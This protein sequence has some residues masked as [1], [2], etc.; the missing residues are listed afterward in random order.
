MDETR[1]T[2][3][4]KRT[5]FLTINKRNLLFQCNKSLP[6]LS[7]CNK[8]A[9]NWCKWHQLL[10]TKRSRNNKNKICV[11]SYIWNLVIWINF[12]T[13]VFFFLAIWFSWYCLG[14]F[15]IFFLLPLKWTSC[16]WFVSS[17]NPPLEVVTMSMLGHSWYFK[18]IFPISD[19]LFTKSGAFGEISVY[20]L[21]Q[22]DQIKEVMFLSFVIFKQNM[23]V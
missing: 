11:S 20:W 7:I 4:Q 19:W 21:V 5:N 18:W 16:F 12:L 1:F 15:D 23:Y 10:W 14:V 17:R 9:R 6:K 8:I 13:I 22:A 3:K 2:L